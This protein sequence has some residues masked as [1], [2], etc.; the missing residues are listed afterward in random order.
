MGRQA[1]Q[2]R[3]AVIKSLKSSSARTRTSPQSDPQQYRLYKMEREEIGARNYARLSVAECRRV[4]RS[5]CRTYAVPQARIRRKLIPGGWAAEWIK[6]VGT[7]YSTITLNPHKGTSTDLLTILHELAHHI[8]FYLANHPSQHQ[9][10]GPQFMACYIS[11]L[12]TVRFLPRDAM[13]VVC[14]RAGLKYHLPGPS[15]ASLKKVLN[16]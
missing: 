10:H 6:R 5:V 9:D 8:H 2:N 11:I 15:I 3:R 12:D 13:A 14:K 7:R 4:S 1:R 16:Q